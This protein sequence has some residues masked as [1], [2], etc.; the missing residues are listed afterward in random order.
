MIQLSPTTQ[1]YDRRLS[2]KLLHQ[3]RT[4]IIKLTDHPLW[5]YDISVFASHQLGSEVIETNSTWQLV[6]CIDRKQITHHPT[7][8]A[9]CYWVNVNSISLYSRP[10]RISSHLIVAFD[11]TWWWIGQT[12]RWSERLQLYWT[13]Q[14]MIVSPRVEFKV[15]NRST[16]FDWR[17]IRFEML[18]ASQLIRFDWL[19]IWLLSN[20]LRCVERSKRFEVDRMS[21]V[22]KLDRIGKLIRFDTSI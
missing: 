4:G 19:V 10:T 2:A 22:G 20:L 9:D 3:L 7:R 1:V 6:S 11:S 5:Y 12:E 16:S 8:H 15:S 21:G 18:K 17:W 14:T 13:L